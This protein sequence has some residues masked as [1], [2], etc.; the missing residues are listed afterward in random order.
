[1]MEGWEGVL[2]RLPF[3]L[4]NYSTQYFSPQFKCYFE[5]VETEPAA[6]KP[7]QFSQNVMY[8]MEGRPLPYP[9]FVI[10]YQ[11]IGANIIILPIDTRNVLSVMVLC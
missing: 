2:F 5:K 9:T 7:K 4:I 11:Y 3:H 6:G 1:M 8:L 10:L